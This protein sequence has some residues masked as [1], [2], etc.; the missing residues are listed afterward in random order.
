MRWKHAVVLVCA[1]IAAP[2][3]LATCGS[4]FCTVNT[5]WDAHGA[6]A[7]PGWRLDL[8]YERITQDQPQAGSDRVSV[9]QLRR[10]HDEVLTRNRNWLATFDYTVNADWGVA[11]ALPYVD[12]S[13]LHIHNH[14]GQQL[15]E[16]WDF[17]GAG[18]ARV[19]AR[20]R[21]ATFE[22]KEPR[23]G[24]VGLTFGVKLP[25]GRIDV[26]NADGDL[27]ERPLQPGTGTTDALLGAY[28]AQLVP[29]SD[30][31][32]FVQG[33]LQV[34]MNTRDGFKPGQR[35]SLDAG[36]RYDATESFSLMVQM[37]ALVRA[38]DAGADAEPEDSGGT[39][40]FLS[41]GASVAVTKDARLYAFYQVPLDQRVNG[42]Q[43]TA[44]RAALFGLSVRF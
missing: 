3:A 42:V 13:H 11:V 22:D 33:M 43:L 40:W 1:S 36:L 38:R 23:L 2:A 19:L 25:T 34:P 10:H 24:T 31:S 26:R 8:R 16:S 39:S 17:S 4:A 18:D 14:M 21:L 35:F 9:G 5:N 41:P 20:Y 30:L 29:A 15:P 28:Y 37:N 44:R 6:W 27:A 7:E 32:W 12:R